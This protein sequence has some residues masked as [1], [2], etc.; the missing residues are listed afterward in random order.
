[1]NYTHSASKRFI[2]SKTIF[3]PR[4][5]SLFN[6]KPINGHLQVFNSRSIPNFDVHYGDRIQ[7]FLNNDASIFNKNITNLYSGTDKQNI[8]SMSNSKKQIINKT[9]PLK[10]T[11]IRESVDHVK[12]ADDNDTPV[13]ILYAF[14]FN[15]IFCCNR[16]IEII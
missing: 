12:K 7:K 10:G 3:Q 2:S 9:K 16:F 4:K 14:Y 1:M 11:N 8:K 6:P 5:P 15:F 13:R